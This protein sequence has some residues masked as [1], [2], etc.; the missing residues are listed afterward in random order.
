[1]ATRIQKSQRRMDAHCS[2]AAVGRPVQSRHAAQVSNFPLEK[3][4]ELGWELTMFPLCVPTICLQFSICTT[5][6]DSS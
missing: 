2:F 5:I 3:Q 6:D 4:R 1:M